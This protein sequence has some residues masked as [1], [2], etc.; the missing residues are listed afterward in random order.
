MK[1]AAR[2]FFWILGLAVLLV[3]ISFLLPATFKVERSA[4]IKSTPAQVYLL[5]ANFELWHLWAPWFS[6]DDTATKTEISGATASAGASLKWAGESYGDGEIILTD[7]VPGQTVG[8]DI[9]FDE[10][11]HKSKGKFSIA[12]EGD[13]LRVTW[14]DEGDLGYNPINRYFGLLMDRFMGPDFEKGLAT[15][16]MVAEARASWPVIDETVLPARNVILVIDSAG[17]SDYERVMGKAYGDLYALVEKEHLT[18]SGNPFATYLRWDSATMFSVMKICLPVEPKTAGKGRVIAEQL[19]EEKVVR[20][21][22]FGDYSK[23]EPAYKALASYIRDTRKM[24]TGG[25]SEI[26]IT[27]PMTEK[28]TA[29]WETHIVFP[30]K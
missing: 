16:K 18:P 17:P 9:A 14:T 26:Y 20:A 29:K 27:G 13:S 8:Y 15:L 23:M 5:T 4:T 7:L 10:G 21:C 22:Y 30:V 1:I 25:P 3:L 2:V 24:Q 28:D 19:P 6:K 12:S 11:K